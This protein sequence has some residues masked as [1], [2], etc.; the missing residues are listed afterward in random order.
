MNRLLTYSEIG[1]LSNKV[2]F[3]LS[4]IVSINDYVV[5]AWKL[6]GLEV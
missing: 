5:M 4:V 1:K 3:P 6:I 2:G